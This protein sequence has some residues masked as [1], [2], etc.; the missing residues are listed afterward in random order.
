MSNSADIL[1]ATWRPSGPRSRMVLGR[2]GLPS[3]RRGRCSAAQ[4]RSS[5]CAGE[6][7]R[8]QSVSPSCN[9][10]LRES[11]RFR[12]D[13]FPA[14]RW[15]VRGQRDH[16]ASSLQSALIARPPSRQ[17]GLVC[18]KVERLCSSRRGD[19]STARLNQIPLRSASTRSSTHPHPGHRG[20]HSR[21]AR[22]YALSG[23][24]SRRTERCIRSACFAWPG[25]SCHGP[26]RVSASCAQGTFHD[27]LQ[28][29]GLTGG[30][31]H[32]KTGPGPAFLHC[33]GAALLVPATLSFE[34]MS[35]TA[36]RQ[37]RA[38]H[39]DSQLPKAFHGAHLSPLSVARG[40][41]CQAGFGRRCSGCSEAARGDSGSPVQGPNSRSCPIE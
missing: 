2:A 41:V 31:R 29:R 4:S 6:R 12:A 37:L 9:A 21:R 17:P 34:P 35:L 40:L 39:Q 33:R 24:V 11:L 36:P 38:S 26:R 22:P 20:A 16:A 19:S 25:E 15:A 23:S 32:E 10:N 18:C 1:G 14:R 8:Q 30:S 5:E 7:C 3:R 27:Q 28:A 13:C